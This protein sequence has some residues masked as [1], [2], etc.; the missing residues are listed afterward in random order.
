MK[1]KLM[2]VVVASLLFGAVF[3]VNSV[4]R[5]FEKQTPIRIA[6][7]KIAPSHFEDFEKPGTYCEIHND[8]DDPGYFF[9]NFNPDTVAGFAVYMDPAQCGPSPYPFKVTDVHLYLYDPD[10]TYQWPVAI[11]VNIRNSNQGY[12]C[13]G[14]QEVLCSEDFTV[15][16]D[17]A[18]PYMVTLELAAPCCVDQPFFLEIVYTEPPDPDHPHP[19]LLMNVETDPADSCDNWGIYL[20][21]Y[22][23]WAEFW[24]VPPGDAIIRATGYTEDPECGNLFWY[25]KPDKPDQD[26]PSP[27]GMPDFD[28]YQFEDSLVLCGPTAAANC[29]WWFNAVPAGMTP[30]D[31]IRL[32]STYFKTDPYNVGTYVDSMQLGL[33]QYL[34]DYGF[35]LQE[36][37][38]QMPDFFEMEDSLKAC[39]DIILLL[40]FWWYDDVAERWYREGGHFVTMAGVCSESLK[41]AI[42]DPARDAAEYGWPGRVRPLEHPSHPGDPILHNGPTYV[43]HDMYQSYLDNPFPSPGNPFWETD[44]VWWGKGAFSGMNVPEEFRLVTRPAPRDGKNIYTTEVEYAV[45]ICSTSS[46]V[47]CPE[48]PNDFGV[49]DTMYI[50]PWPD[51]LV[52]QGDPPYFVRV[53]IYVTNDLAGDPTWQDSLAGFVIPLSYTHSNPSRYCSLSS[54]W[55]TTDV[56]WVFPWFSTRS[57]FRHIVEGTDTLYHNRMADMAADFMGRD[58]DFRMVDLD[59]TSHFWLSMFSTGGQDQMW[60]ESDRTLLATMTFKL[61]DSMSVCV[62][63][64]FWPPQSSLEWIPIR[65]PYLGKIPRPGTGTSSFEVCFN[66]GPFE[67][68]PPEPFSLLSPPNKAFTPRVVRLDWETATDPDLSDQVTYDL[69]VSTSYYFSSDSTAIDSNL[70]TS[71]HVRTLDYGTYYWKV[72]AEDN[73]GAETWCSQFSSFIVTG[74][75]YSRGDFNG[76]GFINPG[77]VVFSIN[78]LFRN[79]S[80]PQPLEAGDVD[81]DSVIEPGDVVYLINYLFRDGPP[82]CEA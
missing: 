5:S 58:W 3:W 7:G 39:Q 80:A 28:Q 42:S 36:S 51:D 79:G 71:E 49:C 4:A 75:P 52:P 40:G 35:A 1:Q 2:P 62:D 69:Y 23:T 64:C 14:P 21:E 16:S 24:E 30:P 50:E 55:N 9:D 53:P 70:T 47:G 26:F 11:R 44:Y 25:W 81:C 27:S 78:F 61:E 41:I 48:D 22:F 72:K 17:S 46:W 63:T 6:G 77:D 73:W 74:I 67:N 43:S 38:F 34:N 45:M 32:L 15:D 66:V 31:L 13:D 59:G 12:N 68:S 76:D 8:V 18:Y 10:G 37:T 82:P 65:S 19:S 54:Y 29:L 33:E 20:G 56:L 57:I 60:W